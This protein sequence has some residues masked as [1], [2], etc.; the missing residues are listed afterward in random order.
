MEI[1]NGVLNTTPTFGRVEDYNGDGRISTLDVVVFI[2]LVFVSLL[3][4]A[5]A[6]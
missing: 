5:I 6:T 1:L 4:S 2:G 3:V